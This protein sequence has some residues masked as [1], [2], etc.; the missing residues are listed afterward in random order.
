MDADFKLT[1]ITENDSHSGNREE[2]VDLPESQTDGN[3][4]VDGHEG[5]VG[6]QQD[7]TDEHPDV[8]E[9]GGKPN[10]DGAGQNRSVQQTR[11]ENAA[12]RAAR[13]RAEREA[14]ARAAARADETIAG[15]GIENPYTHQPFRSMS[16]LEEYGRQVK[17]AEM[18]NKAQRTGKTVAELT[19][20]EENRRFITGL[21]QKAAA[22]NEKRLAAGA[23]R[24]FIERD[25]ID[26]VERH[27][28][29]DVGQLEKN[30]KF[31]DFC[32][33]RFGKEPL[34][35]LY[36]SYLSLV[37]DAGTAA[38]EKSRSRSERSTGSG[39][40]GGAALSPSQARELE[41]WNRDNPDMAMTAKEFLSR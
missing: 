19:E 15:L 11:E 40:T 14:Q 10:S 25:V 22:E 6:P 9:D 12:I 5:G 23:Q 27:P 37:N 7:E 35:N 33:S 20:E 3:A 18:A 34:A 13:I 38:L 4:D 16:E 32:G 8:G 41:R 26:F 28:N 36:D 30:K 1:E 21:R 39:S 29:V 17:A 24:A 31:R 2:V